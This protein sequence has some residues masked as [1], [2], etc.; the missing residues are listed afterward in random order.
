[1]LRLPDI[2]SIFYPLVNGWYLGEWADYSSCL[3]DAKDAQYVMA[4]VTGKYKG[5]VDF[6]RGGIGKYTKGFST[7]M[8]LCFPKQCSLDEVRYFTEDLINTYATGVG[9]QD[10]NIAYVAASNDNQQQSQLSVGALITILIIIIGLLISGSSM[11]VELS[12]L[13]DKHQLKE[14]QKAELLYE[15]SK[16]RRLTQYDCILL[17]RKS[18]KYQKI[19]PLSL[20]RCL[21]QLNIQPR[22]YRSIVQKEMAETNVAPEDR[23]T[24]NLRIFNGLR[25]SALLFAVWGMTF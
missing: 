3:A 12:T 23:V 21:I 20:L 18:P 14:P 13:G 24:Q 15:A 1:M 4:T 7:R 2:G 25:A 9:W 16:F 22:G 5:S 19:I 6:T 10:V 11:F 8:G 17:Q